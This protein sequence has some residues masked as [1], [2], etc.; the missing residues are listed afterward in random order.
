MLW[1]F[2]P[3]ITIEHPGRPGDSRAP[4]EKLI[5]SLFYVKL[6]SL[7]K[8]GSALASALIEVR[9]RLA[10][11]PHINAI[12]RELLERK[13]QLGCSVWGSQTTTTF[14]DASV[15]QDI[16]EG[17]EFGRRIEIE[18]LSLDTEILLQIDNENVSNCPCRLRDLVRQEPVV[19]DR[20]EAHSPSKTS[21]GQVD[22]HEG[23]TV[24][25][26][27]TVVKIALDNGAALMKNMGV[28]SLDMTEDGLA[29]KISFERELGKIEEAIRQM[30]LLYRDLN[31]T[32]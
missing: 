29:E 20:E 6:V 32:P 28:G 19:Y 31:Q 17:R 22:S 8:L 16:K 11:G 1:D 24:V 2:R 18:V 27:P 23:S 15:W 9:C 4:A 5:A 10:A 3:W 12:V 26:G 25:E 21:F 7:P 14:C 30:G 13:S